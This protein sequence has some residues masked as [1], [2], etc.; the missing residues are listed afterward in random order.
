MFQNANTIWIEIIALIA[1]VCF[2]ALIVSG[3]I[4]K[5]VRHLPTGD[6][7]CCHQGTKKMLKKYHRLYTKKN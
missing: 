7:A 2:L 1:I 4:Y 5:K 3:Y 6:C